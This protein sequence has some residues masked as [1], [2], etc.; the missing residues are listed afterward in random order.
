M[1]R[2]V[3]DDK[4]DV[5]G[6]KDIV[7]SADS[8]TGDITTDTSNIAEA[9]AEAESIERGAVVVLKPGEYK[10]S[11]SHTLSSKIRLMGQGVRQT[12]ITHSGN[13]TCFLLSDPGVTGHRSGLSD[14]RIEGNNGASALGIEYKDISYAAYLK[15]VQIRS[16][17]AGSAWRLHNATEWTEGVW[18]D[19]ISIQNCAVGVGFKRSGTGTES[20][21]GVNFRGLAI[22]VPA[23]G[24]GI[25]QGMDSSTETRIY[26]SFI[27]GQIWLG[28]NNAIG[29][30]N[31]AN[32]TLYRS[33]VFIH[34]EESGGVTGIISL[35]N[36]EGGEFHCSGPGV[37]FN[38]DRLQVTPSK[39]QF[40][41][42]W[43]QGASTSTTVGTA[44]QPTNN[45]RSNGKVFE[46][47][48]YNATNPFKRGTSSPLASLT[49]SG[50]YY[51]RNFGVG[52]DTYHSMQGGV[53]YGATA[54]APSG[55]T[56]NRVALYNN[57]GTQ[58]TLDANA[59]KVPISGRA[60][61]RQPH[62]PDIVLPA[63]V[64]DPAILGSA[65]PGIN[66]LRMVRVIIPRTGMLRDISVWVQVQAGNIMAAVY[67]TGDASAG[68]RTRL[69]QSGSVAVGAATAWQIIGDPNIAV[70]AGQ[71]LDFAINSDNSSLQVGRVNLGASGA[72]ALP[73]G[74]GVAPGG[75][76]PKYFALHTPGSFTAPATIAEA[77]ISANN[78]GVIVI[79]RI[80]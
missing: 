72:G 17:T 19:N 40:N 15:R 63:L 41:M 35:R 46:V 56:G 16:Y 74:F 38:T 28:G 23:N 79:G 52:T 73:T 36:D 69:W 77:S 76:S 20:F 31:R 24:I 78:Q 11:G 12:L 32:A 60:A 70:T 58:E 57:A 39:T 37:P 26:N 51:G 59:I 64:H 62:I 45:S 66:Q 42:I 13:N 47:H 8:P 65:G 80:S 14:L 5:L 4:P 18:C 1:P 10:T 34:G 71:H 3:F 25:D 33:W 68:N 30:R 21:N 43:T 7:I 44:F 61:V 54:G 27:E 67:D 55:L 6:P 2:D 29:W 48:G 9:I 75:A 22:N 50:D 53:M 49:D